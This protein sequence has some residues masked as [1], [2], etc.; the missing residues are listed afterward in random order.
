MADRGL[1]LNQFYIPTRIATPA[2]RDAAGPSV[3]MLYGA[4][5]FDLRDSPQVISVPDTHDRYYTIQLIDAFGNSFSYIGRRATGTAAAQFILMGPDW[6]GETPPGMTPIRAATN[7]ITAVARTYVDGPADLAA[8][9]TVQQNFV[10]TPFSE[11]HAAAKPAIAHDSPL[12]LIP[13]FHPATL[14]AGFYDEL[15]AALRD[16]PPPVEDRPLVNSFKAIGIQPGNTPSKHAGRDL[17]EI[18]ERAPALADADIRNQFTAGTVDVADW[19]VRYGVT[20][21]T[22]DPLERAALNYYGVGLQIAKENIYF[23]YGRKVELDGRRSCTIEFASGNLPPVDAFWSIT[24]YGI[25]WYLAENPI[26]RYAIGSP[27]KGLKFGNDG[28]LRIAIQHADPGNVSVNWLPAPA[29][30]YQLVL[31]CYQPREGIISG[32]YRPPRPIPH[33]TSAAPDADP[34]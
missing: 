29:G 17:K 22:S 11:T 34:R 7:T 9:L 28:S 18:L 12:S 4:A 21:H 19:Q 5:W 33:T 3:D 20:E 23:S 1:A 32:A 13:V 25:D 27:T 26:G 15:C 31:R 14:G 10:I 6:R 16:Y 2:D 30:P 24:L 8:A